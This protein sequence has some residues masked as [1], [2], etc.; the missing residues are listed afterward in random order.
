MFVSW[1]S[2][3]WVMTFLVNTTGRSDPYPGLSKFPGTH[4]NGGAWPAGGGSL[5]VAALRLF[6]LLRLNA[7]P[8][9]MLLDDAGEDL[10]GYF[11]SSA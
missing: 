7:D 3:D 9:L 8:S 4:L 2:I 1:V 10:G 11:Y 6:T 5:G